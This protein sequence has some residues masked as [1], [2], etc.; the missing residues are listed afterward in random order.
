MEYFGLLISDESIAAAQAIASRFPAPALPR[1]EDVRCRDLW[2]GIL[3]GDCCCDTC[4]LNPVCKGTA[5]EC[6]AFR[7]FVDKGRWLDT[8]IAI[9]LR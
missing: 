7:H 9:G 4:N 1:D 3:V 2:Q 5:H 6:R 8:D